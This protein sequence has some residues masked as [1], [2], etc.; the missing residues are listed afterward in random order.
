MGVSLYTSRIILNTLGV[1]DFGIYNIAGGVVILFSFLNSAMTSAT[2]RFLNFVTGQN[3]N[4][5]V[6]RVFSM[7]MTAHF[8]IALT[9]IVL[10]ETVGL[11]FLNTQMNIPAERMNAA[12]WVYQF[13]I[14][15]F[16]I[17]IIR[18]PYNASILAYEKMS[19]YAFVSIA[20]VTLKL[21]IVFL[22]LYFGWDKLK[23]YSVLT[24]GISFVILIFYKLYCNGAFTTCRYNFIWDIEL[25]K[26]L[27]RFSGWS[28]FGSLANMGAQQ[29]LNILLNI[30]YGVSVNAA[31]GIANQVSS[32]I[33]GF[34]SNFQVAFNP[35]II[36]S[37][38]LNDQKY[39][40]NLIF[41]SSKFSYY[42]LFF[43][44]LPIL[45]NTNFIF[46]LW[47]KNVP[48]Y[49]VTFCRLIILFMLIDAISAPL[50]MSVQ[51][52][53]NIRNYQILMGSL[54]LLNLPLAY[55]ALKMG[56]E[57]QS[58]LIV[59]VIINLLTFFVRIFYLKPRIGLPTL[60]YIRE[61]VLV[62]TLVSLMALPLPL[63]V[64][65]YIFN[66]KGLI[67]STLVSLFSAGFFIYII[68]LSKKE[69]DFIFSFISSKVRK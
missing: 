68:G 59:R 17:Q 14:L 1:K 25:Y 45:I 4:T 5:E 19:F 10:S 60:R 13:S 40:M 27:M 54:I 32:A 21:V 16:C 64:N 58:I 66:L 38:A 15:T 57:P 30:F 12:N 61:V 37:Y 36:K 9:V 39:F 29:G 7:S 51:A 20:E 67:T 63:L 28:L 65:H 22:L 11:W 34:V 44:S 26:K 48:E 46:E 56:C 2:Q 53:G 35:Q 47:L 42:L 18:V 50:W 24:C 69:R 23:L 49:S 31:M 8:S 6:N 52:T 33:N 62:V 41:Q 3:L 43:L 55:V